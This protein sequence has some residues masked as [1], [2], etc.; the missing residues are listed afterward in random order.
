MVEEARPHLSIH[1]HYES[2]RLQI[3]SLKSEL[4]NEDLLLAKI[5]DQ[6][7]K[8]ALHLLKPGI[9][10]LSQDI[11]KK[12]QLKRE[13]HS[14]LTLVKE[15]EWDLS[16][17]TSKVA[18]T[19]QDPSETSILSRRL[20]ELGETVSSLQHKLTFHS[21]INFTLDQLLIYN[22][23]LDP[24]KKSN[25]V[26]EENKHEEEPVKLEIQSDLES[27]RAMK[28]AESKKLLNLAPCK[29]PKPEVKELKQ[30]SVSPERGAHQCLSVLTKPPAKPS[31]PRRPLMPAKLKSFLK[32]E[33]VIEE[34]PRREE[35][36]LN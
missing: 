20:T 10:K 16:L 6:V 35:W 4:E 27:I 11:L 36:K 24:L 12:T 18:E 14:A 13:H 31:L 7:E 25:L 23:E 17:Y 19:R 5:R 15:S 32:S 9:L 26:E 29:L 2:I 33:S 21:L 8:K 30:R 22:S 34:H 28:Q 1:A 3:A